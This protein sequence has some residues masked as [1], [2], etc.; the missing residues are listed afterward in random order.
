MKGEG[1][2]KR[3]RNIAKVQLAQQA[4]GSVATAAK[5]APCSAEGRREGGCEE[6]RKRLIMHKRLVVARAEGESMIIADVQ[7][8]RFFLKELCGFR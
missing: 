1:G 4:A 8:C 5:F 3:G 7:M 6:G 2:T